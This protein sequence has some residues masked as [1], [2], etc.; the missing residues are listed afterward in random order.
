MSGKPP[1][2]PPGELVE[3]HDDIFPR[4]PVESSRW[5]EVRRFPRFPVRS[6]VEAT[7]YPREGDAGQEPQSCSLMVRDLSRG[8]MNILHVE[9]LFP[10]QRIDVMLHNATR[11]AVEVMWCRRLANRCYTIGCRF[12]KAEGSGPVASSQ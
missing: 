5:D 6:E 12:V 9:Q 3:A 1:P 2:P 7:I 4:G 11:R 8:G 10:G